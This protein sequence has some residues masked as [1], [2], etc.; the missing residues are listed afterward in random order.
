MLDKNKRANQKQIIADVADLLLE[1]LDRFPEKERQKRIKA[2]H[3]ALNSR[4]K[5]GKTSKPS[6]TRP[7]LR[8]SRRAAAHR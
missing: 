8:L 6:S 7:S 5:S 4:S 2:V 1:S 3:K